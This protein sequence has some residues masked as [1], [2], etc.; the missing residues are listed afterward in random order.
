MKKRYVFGVITSIL[1]VIMVFFNPG[2]DKYVSWVA[3]R[4]KEDKGILVSIGVD[5]LAK[6]IIASSTTKNDYFFFSVY[7]T[8]LL[9]DKDIITLGVMNQFIPIKSIAF[10]K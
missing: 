3:E 1:V 8:N 10:K 6:P 2:Q 5:Y 4:I 7:H 9:S